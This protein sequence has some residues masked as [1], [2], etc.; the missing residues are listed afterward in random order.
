MLVVGGD[1]AKRL[2]QNRY[3]VNDPIDG[4]RIIGFNELNDMWGEPEEDADD[5]P[6]HIQRYLMLAI[7]KR[8]EQ[9]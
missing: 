8:D 7:R 1:R 4:R 3:I 9:K 5:R 2:E 6:G